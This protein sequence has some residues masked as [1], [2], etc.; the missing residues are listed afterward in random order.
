MSLSQGT[1]T[2]STLEDVN[3]RC[4]CVSESLH[5]PKPG[6]IVLAIFGLQVFSSLCGL[7]YKML[8]TPH[9]IEHY[10]V[11]FL[12]LT[13]QPCEELLSVKSHSDLSL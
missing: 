8:N 1:R 5:D 13:V 2:R 7:V 12:G 9:P 11:P 3:K 4:W 6:E 10:S